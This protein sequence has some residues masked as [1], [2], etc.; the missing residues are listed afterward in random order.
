MPVICG[1]RPGIDFAGATNVV[2]GL[3]KSKQ[4]IIIATLDV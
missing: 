2:S 4:Q 3:E 1:G